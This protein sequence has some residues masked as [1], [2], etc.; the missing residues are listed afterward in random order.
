MAVYGEVFVWATG[1]CVSRTHVQTVCGRDEQLGII[2]VLLCVCVLR[3][4]GGGG[5]RCLHTLL[6]TK[7]SG[8]WP[9]RLIYIHSYGI[10]LDP[11]H[12]RG[13]SLQ[14]GKVGPGSIYRFSS[15]NISQPPDVH[16]LKAA[17]PDRVTEPRT[18]QGG[19]RVPQGLRDM[20]AAAAITART[21]QIPST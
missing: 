12:G 13:R 17:T 18:K 19:C 3:G 10:D 2:M 20:N 21:P 8:T 7:H 6:T 14:Q 11:F 9:E 4:G 5:G 1:V 16:S 15:V